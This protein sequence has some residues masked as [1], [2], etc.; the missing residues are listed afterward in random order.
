MPSIQIDE[1]AGVRYLQF[2]AHWIQGAMQLDRPWALELEY[3]RSMMLPLLAM[4]R[5]WPRNVL[6]IG[7]GAGSLAKFLYRYQ[8]ASR[9]D[10]V[11]IDPEVALFAW[12]FFRLP[13]ESARF[14]VEFDD[15]FRFVARSRARYDL[16][17][18]D[19]FD[20]RA[21][22]G[23]LDS[24]AF[25]RNCLARLAPGGMVVANLIGKKRLPR[26]GMERMRR[27]FGDRIV[28]LPPVDEANTIVLAGTGRPVHVDREELLVRAK[29]LRARTGLNLAPLIRSLRKDHLTF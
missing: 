25:Y 2:G 6:Q 12:Q 16:V 27:V 8:P 14:R 29:R 1:A 11:E 22:A 13:A 9:I 21:E 4:P 7:L 26:E 20:S 10:V 28:V 5:G 17:L 18:I 3:A 23:R 15:A 19:G 24:R